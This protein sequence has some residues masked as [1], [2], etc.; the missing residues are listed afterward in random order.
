VVLGSVLGSPAETVA[1]DGS[2]AFDSPLELQAPASSATASRD[3]TIVVRAVRRDH[4]V[5]RRG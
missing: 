4:R 3:A 5:T 2:P 1:F